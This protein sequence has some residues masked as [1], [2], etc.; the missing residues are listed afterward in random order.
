VLHGSD[1]LAEATIYLAT[2]PKSNRAYAAF[3][4]AQAAV[5]A[6]PAEPVRLH[7]RNTPTPLM[8]ELGYGAEYRYAHDDDQAYAP[9]EYL[10]EGLRDAKWYAPTEAGHERTIKERMDRWAKLKE[11][12]AEARPHRTP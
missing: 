2:A 3:G 10:P 12:A 6:H 11:E 9:Q 4:E 7:I 8:K 1:A 5:Q